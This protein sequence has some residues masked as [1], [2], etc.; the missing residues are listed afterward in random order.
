MK[1]SRFFTLFAFAIFSATSSAQQLRGFVYDADQNTPL[2]GVTISL[3]T[4]PESNT[5]AISSD[6]NGLFMTDALPPGIYLCQFSLNGFEPILIP[7]VR[8]ASGKETILDVALRSSLITLADV[9]IKAAA[10]DRRALQP[11]GEV[12][13]TRE[14][15]Q[16]FP[17][18][19]FDPARLALAY[20]GVANT[21]DQ[22]NGLSIRGNSPTNLRWRLEGVEVT[23]PNHLPNAGTF[24]D[25]PAT[26]SGGVLLFSAQLLDNS[27]LLTGNSPP[28]YGDALGGIMDIYWRRGNT[29]QH[30]FT[31]QAGLI[32]L[33][34]AA[35]GPLSKK[36]G[37]SYLVNYRY[38]TVGLLGQLGVSFGGEKIS[39][40]DLAFKLGFSGKNGG[41]WSV[42][43]LGGYSQNTFSP[44][45][46]STEIKQYKDL[47]TIDFES[48]TGILGVSNWRPLGRNTTLKTTAVASVQGNVRASFGDGV[49]ER[50][51][52]LDMKTGLSTMIS[53]R[54]NPANRFQGGFLAQYAANEVDAGILRYYGYAQSLVFQP[55][56]NWLWTDKTDHTSINIGLHSLLLSVTGDSANMTDF[57]VEPRLTITRR[58]NER[59]RLAFSAGLTSQSHPMWLYA[60]EV[61]NNSA[62]SGHFRGGALARSFQ[63]SMRHTWSPGS[64]WAVKTELF[65]QQQYRIPVAAVSNAFS[66]VNVSEVHV[67]G[68]LAATGAAENKGI[69]LSAE[70]YLAAGWF[71][72]ANTTLFNARYQGSDGV[73]RS[74]RWNLGHIANLTAGKE[75]Q[76]DRWPEKTRAFGVNGRI[77]WAGGQHAAPVDE[78]ASA[79]AKATVYDLTNGYSQQQPGFVR[80]DLRVYWRHNLGKRRNSL[81]A[82]DF[83]NVTFQKNTAYQY[84]E[85]YT[86]RVETKEQLGLV[87]NLSWRLEW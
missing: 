2:S 45:A 87:P 64:L 42:F 65:Y 12:P 4:T 74:S 26:S 23:N 71:L 19:F 38:S 5:L 40:Q 7:E 47:F 72:L 36:N 73:W 56:A 50:D 39:Y 33:D 75:W 17:A 70:R 62:G 44:S 37:H 66:L 67:L 63:V 30:E 79:T 6:A 27:A 18:T 55:W 83:Q 15:T 35:E 43:G 58:I 57:S 77:T 16:R 69:E 78:A 41:R 21:D 32:G 48:G 46:D 13:L 11:L 29:E 31:A 86:G 10:P 76:R 81:F 61:Q 1:S 68:P 9:T 28:G 59:H 51:T 22:A 53:H 34:V 54:V 25:R 80:L 52:G 85:P 20:P 84:Y 49:R 24:S 8:L 3:G 82:M 60:L 14:Q